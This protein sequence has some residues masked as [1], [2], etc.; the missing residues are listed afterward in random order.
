[1][2]EALNRKVQKST[3]YQIGL[4]HN[5]LVK[6]RDGLLLRQTRLSTQPC[7]EKWTVY[8]RHVKLKLPR[9]PQKP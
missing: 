5:S 3:V 4:D 2:S 9:G 7:E 1:M 8:A 6:C